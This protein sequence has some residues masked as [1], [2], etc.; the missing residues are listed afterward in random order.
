MQIRLKARCKDSW[1]DDVQNKPYIYP[2]SQLLQRA[3]RLL[4]WIYIGLIFMLF[5]V[6]GF[7]RRLIG[8]LLD[9]AH[10][11]YFLG[12]I[13]RG[14]RAKGKKVNDSKCW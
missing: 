5:P 8:K 3:Q 2:T 7:Y 13:K 1:D 6:E 9:K 10:P 12:A 14:G 11:C 4:R